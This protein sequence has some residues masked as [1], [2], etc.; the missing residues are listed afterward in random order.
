M[1]DKEIKQKLKDAGLYLKDAAK[2]WPKYPNTT[3]QWI[4]L[5]NRRVEEALPYVNRPLGGRKGE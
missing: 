2:A 5:A 3:L 4:D 1:D